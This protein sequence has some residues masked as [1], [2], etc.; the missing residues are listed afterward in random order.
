MAMK[1]TRQ[2]QSFRDDDSSPT[3]LGLDPLG[4][5]S[6]GS[7]GVRVVG[8]PAHDGGIAVG[9][10]R[11]RVA[12]LGVSCREDC[13]Q[14]WPLLRELRHRSLPLDIGVRLRAEHK[15][16]ESKDTTRLNPA[17]PSPPGRALIATLTYGGIFSRMRRAEIGHHHHVALRAARP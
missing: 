8:P 11:N 13:D 12:L 5:S 10:Q 15:R 1:S 16:I 3:E 17:G 9:G 14:F 2:P 4:R 6:A 7:P